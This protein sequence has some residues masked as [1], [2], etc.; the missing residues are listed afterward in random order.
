MPEDSGEEKSEQPSQRK[1]HKAH[2]KGD[3]AFSKEVPAALSFIIIVVVFFMFGEYFV[4]HIEG[5][6]AKYLAF[7]RYLDLTPK[8]FV[9]LMLEAT[10]DMLPILAPVLLGAMVASIGGSMM[11]TGPQFNGEALSLKLER[12][13]PANGLKRV[14]SLN[15]L[16]EGVKAIAK[17]TLVGVVAWLAFKGEWVKWPLLL[18]HSIEVQI[19][20]LLSVTLKIGM[21]IA[22]MM[23]VLAVFDWFFQIW[24]W[25][26]KQKMSRKELQDEQKDTEG[27]P[28]IKGRQRNI[29]MQ[30]AMRR[31]MEEVPK[32]DVIITNPEHVAVALR[33]DREKH[34]APIVVAKGQEYLAAR[35]RE[36]ADEHGV[37]RIE[38][39]PL[40]RAL[41]KNCK[42]GDM[43]PLEFYKTVAEI[44][45]YVYRVQNRLAEWHTGAGLRI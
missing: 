30:M 35:I 22:L 38:N 5:V 11:Q 1:I 43:I 15:Q 40:A 25:T 41:Y 19:G 18:E 23:T 2:E 8:S 44:L 37:L 16:M 17:F 4:L 21:F 12:L 24:S 31:M 34:L 27:N 42:V 36:V 33:Y 6:C 14:F 29:Q 3:F 13:L 45:A 7:D 39:K 28:L 32:A 10:A 26:Q 20:Y 9:D